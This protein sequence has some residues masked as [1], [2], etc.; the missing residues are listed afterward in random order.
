MIPYDLEHATPTFDISQDFQ[1]LLRF[2]ALLDCV[3]KVIAV[4]LTSVVR[5]TPFL[6]NHRAN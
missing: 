2:L 4:A 3:S 1:C 5:K 6:R